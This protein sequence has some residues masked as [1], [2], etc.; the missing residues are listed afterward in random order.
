M[1]LAACGHK[2]ALYLPKEDP[3]PTEKM[4]SAEQ[5]ADDGT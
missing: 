5:E 3:P 4:P 1:L 2:G